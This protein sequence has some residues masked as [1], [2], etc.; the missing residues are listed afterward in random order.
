M[1]DPSVDVH[2]DDAVLEARDAVDLDVR[3]GLEPLDVAVVEYL[4]AVNAAGAQPGD[5]RILVLD[6]LERHAVEVGKILAPV[7]RVALQDDL[8][9][10]GPAI[11]HE[12]TGTHAV[13]SEVAPFLDAFLPDDL[14]TLE[15]AEHAEDTGERLGEAQLDG[16]RIDD[17]DLLDDGVI[18]G[19]DGGL[20]LQPL[21]AVLD[22]VGDHLAAAVELH[23]LAQSED[24]RRTVVE[25]FPRLG[26][27][28][29]HFALGVEVGQR[30]V[31]QCLRAAGETEVWIE[32]HRV[33]REGRDQDPPSLRL[34][35]GRRGRRRGRSGGRR[36]GSRGR[37]RGGCGRRRLRRR[38]SRCRRGRG[39]GHGRGRRCAGCAR[40]RQ[41]HR[42][43]C[44]S[45]ADGATKHSSPGEP[46][47]SD[48]VVDAT[49]L[50]GFH[51]HIPSDRIG[52]TGC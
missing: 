45:H 41:R 42:R 5:D 29:L 38:G 4:D 16:V 37:R 35:G 43:E 40:P 6:D 26:Q 31:H 51:L 32:R 47:R 7:V 14:A 44:P 46:A 23:A 21:H 8:A 24:D 17:I 52:V 50:P 3:V 27:Q 30:L 2:R 33:G 36:A 22:V 39:R 12:R 18:G 19:E 25:H 34:A 11:Q 20:V 49:A 15:L 48:L 1:P 9:A 13:A 10:A 28:R